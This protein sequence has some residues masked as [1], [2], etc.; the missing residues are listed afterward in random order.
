MEGRLGMSGF[1]PHSTI[2]IM[3]ESGLDAAFFPP[4]AVVVRRMSHPR[5]RRLLVCSRAADF[6]MPGPSRFRIQRALAIGGVG[7][8]GAILDWRVT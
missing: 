5:R 6:P 3:N 2:R 4:W 7:Q 1:T 8:F